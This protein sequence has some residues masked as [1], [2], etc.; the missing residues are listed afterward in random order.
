M[1]RRDG[2]ETVQR[3]EAD[4][5][6]VQQAAQ[7]PDLVAVP[8]GEQEGNLQS[9]PFTAFFWASTRRSIPFLARASIWSI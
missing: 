8:G 6:V 9:R 5:R 2:G 4:R 7:L 3:D 1:D